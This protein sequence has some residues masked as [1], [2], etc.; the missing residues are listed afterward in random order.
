[1]SVPKSQ[2]VIRPPDSEELVQQI[3]Y[4]SQLPAWVVLVRQTPDGPWLG[5][6]ENSFS[7]SYETNYVRVWPTFTGIDNI[8]GA[9]HHVDGHK[10][11]TR[12]ADEIAK[13]RPD[14]IVGWWGREDPD[15]PVEV[16]WNAWHR[17]TGK[18]AF[19]NAPMKAKP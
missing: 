12:H 14:W 4:R 15:C 3:A 9:K 16:D 13:N 6:V 19:R 11:A 17:G 2:W 5:Y 18:Y 1:M 10:D 7:M 8:V